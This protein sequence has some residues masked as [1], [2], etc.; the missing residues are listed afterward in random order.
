MK[1]PL[2]TEV[3]QND[4]QSGGFRKHLRFQMKTHSVDGENEGFWKRW[5]DLH[6][7][8]ILHNAPSI[9]NLFLRFSVDG[10]KRY[11]NASVDVKLLL[12]FQWNENGGFWEVTY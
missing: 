6:I 11:E 7:I 10:R 3:F 1:T 8:Y 9:K 5:F 12:R 2:K 4:S